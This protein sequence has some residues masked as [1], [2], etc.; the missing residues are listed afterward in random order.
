MRARILGSLAV[1]LAGTGLAFAEP[2]VASEDGITKVSA[3]PVPT[4]AATPPGTPSLLPP[5][6]PRSPYWPNPLAK[7]ECLSC[8]APVGCGT[9]AD[10][11]HR[12][13]VWA[14]A[15]YL[16]WWIKKG[17]NP[18]PLITTGTGGSFGILG[19]PN[20]SVLF[21][22][23]DLDFDAFSGARFTAGFWVDREHTWGVEGSGFF[24]EKRSVTFD[25]TST[26]SG[27]PVL[28]RPVVN[29]ITG[30]ETVE[31][32]SA[33]NVASGSAHVG[34]FTHL[35]GWDVDFLCNWYHDN[36]ARL[37]LMAGYRY[38]NLNESISIVDNTMLLP[39]GSSGFAG[40]TLIVP[41]NVTV[42]DLFTTR[43]LFNGGQIGGRYEYCGDHWFFNAM[44]KLGLGENHEVISV[45]G[46]TQ[47]TPVGGTTSIVNGGLLA[48][49]TNSGR[50]TRDEFVVVPECCINIG[51][52][53]NPLVRAYVGYT[54][55]YVSDVVRPG[56]QIS[57]T[58][59][60]ALVPTSQTF[61]TVPTPAL[62]A[63]QFKTTDFWAQGI[64]FGLEVRY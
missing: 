18:T 47:Q 52:Q 22:G 44:G 14:S 13:Q 4:G 19:S 17:P 11:Y 12:G 27:A 51:L 46:T 56:D 31:L 40:N 25:A 39:G 6:A 37:D 62:P 54:F 24:L 30:Q 3:G 53:F 2:P 28:A 36:C 34:A 55:L 33:P 10:D 35:Y 26:P 20:T 15:D 61:G 59:N 29:A 49:S 60:P 23:D 64:N 63:A 42:G 9:G 16:L 50:S 7:L 43:N 32:I 1:L 5:D 8:P 48:L 41:T 45:G 58:V 57:R 38:L 21:G